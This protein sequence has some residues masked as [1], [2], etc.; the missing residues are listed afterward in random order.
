MENNYSGKQ[1]YY[2]ELNRDKDFYRIF[3]VF[4]PNDAPLFPLKD[5]LR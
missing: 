2:Q 3:L 5:T 4:H 1:Y